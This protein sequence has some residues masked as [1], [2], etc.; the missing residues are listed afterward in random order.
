[1]TRPALMIE[2]PSQVMT[3]EKWKARRRTDQAGGTKEAPT[4]LYLGAGGTTLGPAL[5]LEPWDDPTRENE[6]RMARA[7]L[8]GDEGHQK[9]CASG[10]FRVWE[11][12]TC[13]TCAALGWGAHN[14]EHPPHEGPNYAGWARVYV[15]AREPIPRAWMPAFLAHLND[16]ENDGY[17]E[18]LRRD[19]ATFGW[20]LTDERPGYR[21][22]TATAENLLAWLRDYHDGDE[23]AVGAWLDEMLADDD[24]N[25]ASKRA[26]RRAR[27]S[28]SPRRE[29]R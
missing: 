4:T 17:R 14:E 9:G 25:E 2:S 26:A 15:Q 22:P 12:D 18:A 13:G 24:Y 3:A 5:L 7:I 27:Y 23:A 20:S 6:A 11:R 1:M 19:V 21:L 8:R 10:A 29:A 28:V 16:E